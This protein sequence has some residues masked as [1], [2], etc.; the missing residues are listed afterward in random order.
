MEHSGEIVP[1]WDGWS[2]NTLDKAKILRC[3]HMGGQTSDQSPKS[4]NF[5]CISIEA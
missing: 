2:G 5:I 4:Q 3:C 1:E